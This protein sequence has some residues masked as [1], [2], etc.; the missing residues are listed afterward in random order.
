MDIQ[1][2]IEVGIETEVFRAGADIAHTGLRRLLHH[3]A[4][5]A[6]Q[7]KLALARHHG[8]LD[9]QEGPSDFCPGKAVHQ[10]HMIILVPVRPAV[11]GDSQML[12][13]PV[14]RYSVPAGVLLRDDF[15]DHL[16]ADG[17]DLFFQ[18]PHTCFAGIFMDH[19]VDSLFRECDLLAFEAVEADLLGDEKIPRDQV[20][21]VRRVPLD[22]DHLHAVHERRRD[23]IGGIGGCDEHDLGHIILDVHIMIAEGTVLL[24][25]QN[26]QQRSRRIASEVD[27]HLVDLI[28]EKYRVR[29]SGLPEPLNDLPGHRADIG[30]TV[31]LDLGLVA[32]PSQGNPDELPPGRP[33][34]GLAQRGLADARRAYK[35]EYGAFHGPHHLLHGKI[36]DDAVLHLVETEVVLVE[37][38]LRLHDIRLVF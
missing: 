11:S 3:F 5:L 20:L 2:I 26:F 34:D 4:E 17:G 16:P 12:V 24:R 32:H 13:H 6:R 14:D 15:L 29:C 25:I 30:S 36:F 33:G 31:A 35:T 23:R 38:L 21:F 9:S 37:D 28:Q 10:P 8:G 22:P 27:T 1:L 19:R 18:V 7:E